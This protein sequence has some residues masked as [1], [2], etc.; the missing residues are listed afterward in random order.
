MV[1]AK[2]VK[3]YSQTGKEIAAE[4]GLILEESGVVLVNLIGEPGV[5]K[6][7]IVEKI[8][9]LL[10]GK[11]SIAVIEGD[12]DRIRGDARLEDSGDKSVFIESGRTLNPDVY[13]INKALRQLPLENLD[14]VIVETVL[15]PACP[16]EPELGANLNIVVSSVS[17]T[18]NYPDRYPKILENASVVLIN[19][20]DLLPHGQFSL[21]AF[22]EQ[23][24]SINETLKIFPISALKGEGLEELSI[25]LGRMVWKKRRNLAA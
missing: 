5:G 14:L 7:T 13:M 12:A 24:V 1:T 4:N 10:S 19:K 9:P 18:T 23:L 8:L 11:L 20:T 22:I 25:S 15:D 6:T 21:G 17:G 2:A 3:D 16:E